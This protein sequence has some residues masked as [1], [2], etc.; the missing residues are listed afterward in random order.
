MRERRWAPLTL[1]R[2]AFVL[3][4]CVL[5]AYPQHLLFIDTIQADG[6]DTFDSI[7]IMICTRTYC[8]RSA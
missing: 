1:L 7:F 5:G 8:S 2:G 3:G 4:A 6:N